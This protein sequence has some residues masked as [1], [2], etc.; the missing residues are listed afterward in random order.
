MEIGIFTKIFNRT[1]LDETLDAVVSHGIRAIQ[2]NMSCAGL[3][4]LPA[5]IPTYLIDDIRTA[6]LSRGMQMAALSGTYNLIHPD[7]SVRDQGIQGLQALAHACASWECPVITLCTGTRDTDNMWRRHPDNDTPAAWSDL[8]A[9]MREIVPIAEAT[10]V[11]LGVE[12]ELSNV[13][14]SAQ[15]ARRLIDEIG[16]SRLKIIMDGSNLLDITDVT[17]MPDILYQAFDLLGKDIIL[18]HAK[19][20]MAA[21]HEA[22]GAAGTGV[23]NYRLYID[24]LRQAGYDGALILHTLRE[25]QVSASVGFLYSILSPQSPA[26]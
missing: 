23:M 7:R 2:F 4:T 1:S 9:A 13:V 17:R 26:G 14:N 16:S 10:G 11:Y 19:D 21:G 8:V 15:K 6:I 3:P 5:A 25:D 20:L 18:A 24:L 12:P 22:H